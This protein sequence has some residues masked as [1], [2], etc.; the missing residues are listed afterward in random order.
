MTFEQNEYIEGISSI[1]VPLET[2]L[3]SFSISITMP[4]SR[5]PKNI[6]SMLE[7]MQTARHRIELRIGREHQLK[8]RT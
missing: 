2:Y 4:S 6:E 5:F 3:G 1:A 7:A 8:N